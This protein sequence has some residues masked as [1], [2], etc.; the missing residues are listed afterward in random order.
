MARIPPGESCCS[1]EGAALTTPAAAEKKA[2]NS[3]AI[4]HKD[5]TSGKA[6]T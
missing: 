3:A 6:A 5:S 2:M 4:S 1:T